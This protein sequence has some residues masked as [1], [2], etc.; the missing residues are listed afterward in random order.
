MWQTELI[1][2]KDRGVVRRH[3]MVVVLWYLAGIPRSVLLWNNQQRAAVI[4]IGAVLV[5]FLGSW[6]VQHEER[7]GIESTSPWPFLTMVCVF[8]NVPVPNAVP[9]LCSALLPRI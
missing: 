3:G 7:L 2:G 5:Q 6:Q 9:R 1:V 8:L 4:T